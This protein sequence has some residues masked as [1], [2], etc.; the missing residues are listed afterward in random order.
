MAVTINNLWGAETGGLEEASASIGSPTA[1]TT[2][3][4]SGTYSYRLT[5]GDT[6]DFSMFESVASAGNNHIIGFWIRFDTVDSGLTQDFLEIH[7]S[8]GKAIGLGLA[9]TDGNLRV[10]WVGGSTEY[11]SGPYFSDNTWH[12]VELYFQ[13]LNSGDFEVFIDGVSKAS[14]TARDFVNSGTVDTIKFATANVGGARSW[15]LDDMYWLSD[16][17]DETDRLGGCEVFSYR[18]SKAS[19]TP[20]LT[21]GDALDAGQ[22]ADAQ[23]IGF[24]ETNVASYEAAGACTGN[25]TDHC[26]YINGQVCRFLEKNTVP[27]RVFACGLM[28]KLGNWDAVLDSREYQEHI[29][30]HFGPKGINCREYPDTN[31]PSRQWCDLCK[32]GTP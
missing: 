20:D 28:R 11:T 1:S 22:W 29:E 16:V 8:G 21:S 27:G 32:R 12:F 25:H 4:H 7:D 2:Q 30:P 5:P 17:T 3:A 9:F 14:N 23:E 19:A 24:G 15:Y 31:A 26:C 13:N 10:T 18:S 6:L